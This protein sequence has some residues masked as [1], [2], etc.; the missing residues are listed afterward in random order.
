MTGWL[1]VHPFSLLLQVVPAGIERAALIADAVAAAD[2]AAAAEAAGAE[3]APGAAL[4]DSATAVTSLVGCES[5][6]SERPSLIRCGGSSG[7]G[8][9]TERT[10]LQLGVDSLG[11]VALVRLLSPKKRFCL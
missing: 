5:E 10:L 8:E 1:T 4:V 7:G 11:V 9:R 2:A 6:S 3:A